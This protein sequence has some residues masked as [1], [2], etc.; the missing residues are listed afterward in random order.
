MPHVFKKID[1][2]LPPPVGDFG[3]VAFTEVQALEIVEMILS[4]WRVW[5]QVESTDVPGLVMTYKKLLNMAIF[6]VSFPY[7]FPMKNG[8]FP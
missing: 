7:S 8:D 4:S 2:S 3:L 6:I 5:R 1:V